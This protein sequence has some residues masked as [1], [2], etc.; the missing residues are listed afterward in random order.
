MEY[1]NNNAINL[2]IGREELLLSGKFS[3]YLNE[4]TNIMQGFFLSFSMDPISN[5][6]N[7]DLVFNDGSFKTGW[8]P[9]M[10]T[11][12]LNGFELYID[13]SVL[14][15][16]YEDNG[17]ESTIGNADSKY[18]FLFIGYR[19]LLDNQIYPVIRFPLKELSVIYDVNTTI[20]FKANVKCN[21]FLNET[22]DLSHI[23]ILENADD[24]GQ[25]GY[26][27]IIQ[28]INQIYRGR[29]AKQI[30]SG[31]YENGVLKYK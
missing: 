26:Y 3:S 9:V 15:L 14:P 11:A 6:P 7:I 25:D 28:S 1:I 13:N 31:A 19:D 2:K 4:P 8:V 20:K 12:T 10:S 24:Y 27:S 17:T 16:D 30:T 18:K 23:P 5:S 21:Y 22:E 29:D